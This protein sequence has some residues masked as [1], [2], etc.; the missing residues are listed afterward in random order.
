MYRASWV[1]AVGICALA[2]SSCGATNSLRDQQSAPD[3]LHQ[4]DGRLLQC[5]PGEL[6][7]VR[8]EVLHPQ[9]GEVNTPTLDG[10]SSSEALAKELRQWYPG[11]SA[12][13]FDVR[14]RS[15]SSVL[16]VLRTSADVKAVARVT[17]VDDSWRTTLLLGCAD[18][19]DPARARATS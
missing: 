16:Y 13:R 1:A 11:L 7:T 8:P 15:G 19:M 4:N 17:L 18:T 10:R 9:P 6:I 14:E 3:E 5:Q 12:E 2:V